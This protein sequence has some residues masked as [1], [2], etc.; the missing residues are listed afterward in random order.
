ML[1]GI[2]NGENLIAA[3]PNRIAG[4]RKELHLNFLEFASEGPFHHRDG[5]GRERRLRRAKN[6]LA[7]T[8]AI[9]PEVATFGLRSLYASVGG[10]ASFCPT[11]RAT[12]VADRSSAEFSTVGRR[13]SLGF[14]FLKA[15]AIGPRSRGA[16][17]IP[18]LVLCHASRAA[19]G[20]KRAGSIPAAALG[21]RRESGHLAADEGNANYY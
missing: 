2:V 1:I 9:I 3:G 6:A 14:A 4:L 5:I 19:P 15:A 16:A 7:V 12:A 21:Q 20:A 13:K 8:E 17:A 11:G 18:A 10:A